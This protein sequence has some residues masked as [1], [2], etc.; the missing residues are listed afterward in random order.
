M[1][2]LQHK[3]VPSLPALEAAQ[4]AYDNVKSVGGYNPETNT[5]QPLKLHDEIYLGD[6]L[7]SFIITTI[8]A[9]VEAGILDHEKWPSQ[10]FADEDSFHLFIGT[11]AVFEDSL[12]LQESWWQALRALCCDGDEEEGYCSGQELAERLTEA[13]NDLPAQ[14][15]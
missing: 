7:R 8:A 12:K 10:V 3:F 2:L 1:A 4:S 5:F 6:I 9:A 11:L 14:W 13:L 15:A